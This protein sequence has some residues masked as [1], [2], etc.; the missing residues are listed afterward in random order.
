LTIPFRLRERLCTVSSRSDGWDGIC[1]PRVFSVRREWLDLAGGGSGLVSDGAPAASGEGEVVDE[2]R[3]GS[4]RLLAWSMG[5][6]VVSCDGDWRT[7]EY[8][9]LRLE[10]QWCC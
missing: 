9:W 10:I 6:G 5:L 7:E 1:S 8:Q 2:V 4:V 3:K